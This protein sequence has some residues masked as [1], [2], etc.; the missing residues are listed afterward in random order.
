MENGDTQ[1]QNGLYGDDGKKVDPL[2]PMEPPRQ[3]RQPEIM[4]GRGST[5]DE[6]SLKGEVRGS[7]KTIAENLKKTVL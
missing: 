4:K 7:R 2:C 3:Y 5:I 1:C 6:R